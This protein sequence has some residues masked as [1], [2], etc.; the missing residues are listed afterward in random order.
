MNR[1]APLAA[2]TRPVGPVRPVRLRRSTGF[3][4]VE[5]AMVLA[6]IAVMVAGALAFYSSATE[7]RRVQEAISMVTVVRS[8]ARQMYAGQPD[9]TGLDTA[10]IAENKAI[11]NKWKWTSARMRSPWGTSFTVGESSITPASINI[12]MDLD[13]TACSKMLS[14]NWGNLIYVRT[15]ASL[16]DLPV[17]Q[18]R[19]AEYCEV[20]SG[21]TRLS[22]TFGN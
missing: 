7:S 19:I 1:T 2:A 12:A 9:Y 11:P 5:I 18:N 10:V 16:V 22:L 4:L 21:L 20:S 8:I 3:S 13:P 17:E 15:S 14:V 6:I